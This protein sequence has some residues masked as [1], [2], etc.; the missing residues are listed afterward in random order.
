MYNTNAMD[1]LLLFGF[2]VFPFLAGCGTTTE[3]VTE[4]A[5]TT[6]IYTVVAV[7]AIVTYPFWKAGSSAQ[8][9]KHLPKSREYLTR[10]HGSPIAKYNCQ[11]VEIWEY[12]NKQDAD[13]RQFVL[14]MDKMNVSFDVE[15]VSLLDGC[16]VIEGAPPEETKEFWLAEIVPCGRNY[17]RQVHDRHLFFVDMAAK[18]GTFTIESEEPFQDA[19]NAGFIVMYEGSPLYEH[20]KY[21]FQYAGKK[22]IGTRVERLQFGP[23]EST[24]LEV[25]VTD[26][27]SYALLTPYYYDLWISCP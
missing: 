26:K 12:E 9:N 4:V 16:N 19:Q 27:P 3:E 1:R 17:K 14:L 21:K 10:K 13:D 11:G 23:G 22:T 25:R 2:A 18:Q 5:I 8:K 15:K 24:F 20:N 7:P 6:P